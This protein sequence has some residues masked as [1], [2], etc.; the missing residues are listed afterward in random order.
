MTR[1][2]VLT[3]MMQGFSEPLSSL[4]RQRILDAMAAFS[5]VQLERMDA[6]GVRVWP[7]PNTLRN[8]TFSTVPDPI[9]Q[10][11]SRTWDRL[12]L[13]IRRFVSY[14]QPSHLY[15]RHEGAALSCAE[16]ANGGSSVRT[17]RSF[18]PLIKCP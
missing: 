11:K 10:S 9:P 4:Q 12:L 18:C 13:T 6:A 16:L 8:S 14:V 17:C 1:E 2:E 3:H 5:I 7:V 15:R